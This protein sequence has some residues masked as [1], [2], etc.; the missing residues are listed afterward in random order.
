LFQTYDDASEDKVQVLTELEKFMS[1]LRKSIEIYR[2]LLDDI[3]AIVSSLNEKGRSMKSADFK[4]DIE[5]I[6]ALSKLKKICNE[7]QNDL[8]N[9]ESVINSVDY[10]QDDED[11]M[12]L[13]IRWNTLYVK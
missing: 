11:V 8:E 6:L 5:S 4:T 1:K 10:E 9:K 7:Y 13:M 3:V 12:Y 2:I